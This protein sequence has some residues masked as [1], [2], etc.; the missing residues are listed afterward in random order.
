VTLFAR[1]RWPKVAAAAAVLAALGAGGWLVLRDDKAKPTGLDDPTVVE[2]ATYPTE[3]PSPTPSLALTTVLANPRGHLDQGVLATSAVVIERLGPS[4]AW[5]GTSEQ[6]ILLVLVSTEHPF[7][8]SPGAHVSFIGTVKRAP[9]G[10]G[11]SLG[12]DSADAAEVD[13]EG[14]FVETESYAE[15]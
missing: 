13:G 7:T 2:T 11:H 14:A 4:V 5:V 15:S 9:A 10:F 6:R 12:L 8:F 1:R 3:T